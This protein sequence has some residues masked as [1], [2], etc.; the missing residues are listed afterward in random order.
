MIA[1]DNFTSLILF[2]LVYHFTIETVLGLPLL[3]IMIE[4]K[5]KETDNG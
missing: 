4:K 2:A 5:K 1:I 3:F